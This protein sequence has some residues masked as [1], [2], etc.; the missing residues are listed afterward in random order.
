MRIRRDIGSNIEL[1]SQ[2]TRQQSNNTGNPAVD[3]AR[4][5]DSDSVRVDPKLR[6]ADRIEHDPRRQARLEELRRQVRDGSYE[7]D[8]TKV[9]EALVREL[10]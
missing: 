8:R 10:F 1:R 6:E 7:P 4:R 5:T 2:L 9:A 3:Q